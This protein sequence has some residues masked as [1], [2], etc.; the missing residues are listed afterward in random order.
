MRLMFVSRGVHG[1]A[2]P[3]MPL[4]RAARD[5]GHTVAFVTSAQFVERIA[6]NGFDA[7]VGLPG[8]Q[9]LLESGAMV[10]ADFVSDKR[11]AEAVRSP[12]QYIAFDFE[13]LFGGVVAA[14]DFEWL[15]PVV[16]A[17]RPD[18]LVSE[19][20]VVA[21]SLVAARAG[22][23][24]ADHGFG[25]RIP[26][27][28]L[29]LGQRGIAPLRSKI[30]L[31]AAEE[32]DLYGALYLS[33]CPAILDPNDDRPPQRVARF[34]PAMPPAL[35]DGLPGWVA[36]LLEQPTVYLTFG[37]SEASAST[38][39]PVIDSLAAEPLNLIVTTGGHVDGTVQPGNVHVESFLPQGEM[40][41]YCDLVVAHGGAGTTMGA[42]LAGLP[43]VL[44]PKR[45]DQFITA[46][47]VA[48]AGAAIVL[49]PDAASP[50]AIRQAVVTVLTDA[51]YREAA[52]RVRQELEELP[53]PASALE[54]LQA[55]GGA[56]RSSATSASAGKAA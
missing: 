12:D 10:T 8:R 32:D 4:A 43:L 34:R 2:Y 37:T 31:D 25:V 28:I 6:A 50:E 55:L 27:A 18:V 20:T 52:Q 9:E 38:L 33:P 21:A 15:S 26:A 46:D 36:T 51:T 30:G 13:H 56:S 44:L 39:P 45:A 17:W 35:G 19:P 42:L 40:L 54:P 23:P 47:A 1:H 41:P 7:Q 3:L 29:R 16:E 48:W 49:R 53:D 14:V 24:R 11:R 5:A 22:I